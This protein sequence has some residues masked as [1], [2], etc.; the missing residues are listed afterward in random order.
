MGGRFKKNILLMSL[1]ASLIAA[2]IFYV[3]EMISMMMA[4]LGYIPPLMGAWFPVFVFIVLGILLLR[5][6]KT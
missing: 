4:R 6:A 5:H 2:V 3:S 1:L